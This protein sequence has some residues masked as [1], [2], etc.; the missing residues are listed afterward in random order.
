MYTNKEL[1]IE[2]GEIPAMAQDGFKCRNI[3]TGIGSKTRPN[4]LTLI[5]NTCKYGR[6]TG[7]G[8]AAL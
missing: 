3:P 6:R 8:T 1:I 4:T 5:E 7:S 2:R